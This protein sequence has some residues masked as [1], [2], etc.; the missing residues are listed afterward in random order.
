MGEATQ[1]QWTGLARWR[2]N[3]ATVPCTVDGG[4]AAVI[5]ESAAGAAGQGESPWAAAMED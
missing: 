4:D 3:N 5:G 2:A 1:R